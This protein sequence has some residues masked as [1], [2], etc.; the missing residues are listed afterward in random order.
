MPPGNSE[1]QEEHLCDECDARTTGVQKEQ[2]RSRCRRREAVER[3]VAYHRSRLGRRHVNP[4]LRNKTGKNLKQQRRSVGIFQESED[5]IKVIKVQASGIP[6]DV[7]DQGN[8]IAL[9]T[10]R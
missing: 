5:P 6:V 9:Y 1:H 7:D 8:L 4:A 3:R 2:E 10:Q